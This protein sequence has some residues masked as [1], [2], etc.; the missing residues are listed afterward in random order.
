VR[1]AVEVKGIKSEKDAKG[2][3]PESDAVGEE[4]VKGVVVVDVVGE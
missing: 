3:E 1:D 4:K 2:S